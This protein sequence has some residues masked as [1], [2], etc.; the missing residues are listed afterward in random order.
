MPEIGH[1]LLHFSIVE[2]IGV[3]EVFLAKDHKL[4]RDVALEVLPEEYAKDID[5]VARFQR[6]AKL[7][8][9]LKIPIFGALAVFLLSLFSSAAQPPRRWNSEEVSRM[10]WP[11]PG[12][13]GQP[14]AARW[15]RSA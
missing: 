4:G 13:C 2:K 11:K 15:R 6:K 14:A 3:G 12:L 9:T 5:R 7:L 8:E 1:N 10:L